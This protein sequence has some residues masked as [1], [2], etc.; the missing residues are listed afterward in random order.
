M[1][2]VQISQLAEFL[3]T[4]DTGD[5][6]RAQRVRELAADYAAGRYH[7]DPV[8]IAKGLVREATMGA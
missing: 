6:E 8:A 7:P 3:R 2:R 4:P 5:A 1:D